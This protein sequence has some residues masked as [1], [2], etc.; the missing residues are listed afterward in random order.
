MIVNFW[1]RLYIIG[2]LPLPLVLFHIV[3]NL[4]SVG[5]K[6]QL[7]FFVIFIKSLF[8]MSILTDDSFHGAIPLHGMFIIMFHYQAPT[9]KAIF[10]CLECVRIVGSTTNIYLSSEN[11][12]LHLLHQLY[13]CSDVKP[14][15]DTARIWWQNS[16]MN[17]SLTWTISVCHSFIKKCQKYVN[18]AVVEQGLTI[19]RWI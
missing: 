5:I 14:R 1:P 6:R 17:M 8:R 19:T 9:Q 12:G 4:S 2:Y 3:L 15:L 16:C 11:Q 10:L 7:T 18:N 13:F